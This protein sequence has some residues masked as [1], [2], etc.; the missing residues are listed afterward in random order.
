MS[1]K[2]F[3]QIEDKYGL[4]GGLLNAVWQKESGGGK[5]MLSPAGAQGH[6]QFMPGT[7]KQYGLAD[8]ND[9]NQSADAAGRYFR[10]LKSK[11]DGDVKKMLA[12]YNWGPGNVD[13]KGLEKMPAE[14]RDYVATIEPKVQGPDVLSQIKAARAG[15]VSDDDIWKNLPFT[16]HA[17]GIKKAKAAGLTDEQIAAGLG[18]KLAQKDQ[19]NLSKMVTGQKVKGER[20]GLADFGTGLKTSV[21]DTVQ[22]AKQLLDEGAKYAESKLRDT[23]FGRG[24]NALNEA[25]GLRTPE[26]IAADTQGVINARRNDDAGAMDTW[27]GKA[28]QIVGSIGQMVIPGAV[29][30]KGSTVRNLLLTPQNWKQAAASGA[31]FGGIQATADGENR[32]TNAG[33]GAGGSV[34]GYGA[35]KGI[36][37]V[38]QG[39]KALPA[40][41]R[42]LA[43][44]AINKY[45]IDLAADQVSGNRLT[46][47]VRSV[48]K[49]IPFSGVEGLANRQQVQLNRAVAKTFGESA[50]NVGTAIQKAEARLGGEFDKA[51]KGN[52]LKA[53]DAFV[54]SLSK[55]QQSA[56][57]E[58]NDAQM[59]VINRNI[60][61]ILNKVQVDGTIDGQAAY[62]AKKVLD[63][64]ANSQD[65]S[66]AHYA[67][68]LRDELLDTLTRSMS[69][70]DA[71][72]F[73]TAREQW[74]NMR[75]AARVVSADAEGN[76]PM[77]GARLV[78]QAKKYKATDLE[79]IGR[80][81]NQFLKDRVPNSGTVPRGTA[82]A[83]LAGAIDPVTTGTAILGTKAANSLMSS[84]ALTNNL[85]NGNRLF[86]KGQGGANMLLSPAVVNSLTN[87]SN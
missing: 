53:D 43:D 57:T 62:N 48:S 78:E 38:A 24:V 64:L 33:L 41:V 10:D 19:G 75:T 87:A 44:K 17:E 83:V 1:E 60:D 13:K 21:L 2:L 49:D 74:K 46:R 76:I 51:L 22:G 23:A 35:A 39:A 82:A 68:E 73:K 58:L 37:A 25:I 67:R 4:P 11:Y 86:L 47:L 63:R 28:G 72:A 6:F 84:K 8:P 15:G 18:L 81:A 7:A 32:L 30:G 9:L 80:I 59:S 31:A 79:E 16:P 3:G 71:A 12:A 52:A 26:A 61:E 50:D 45:G 70:A 55:L 42:Q 27:Q 66:L 29:A 69:K 34:V 56:R 20:D 54:D 85:I 77:G 5:Y 65:S 14:T 36:G 40:E